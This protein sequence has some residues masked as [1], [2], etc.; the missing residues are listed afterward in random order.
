MRSNLKLIGIVVGGWTFLACLFTPQ[1]YLLNLRLPTPLTWWEALL[2]NLLIFYLWAILTPLIWRL[3]KSLPLEK[4]N[5]LLHFIA[6][7]IFGFP[8]AL[9][10]LI[11]LQQ[12]GYLLSNW[13]IIYESP[14]PLSSLL[15]GMGASNIMLYWV[16]IIISQANIHFRRYREREQSLIQ[17]QLQVLKN[18]LHPHFLFNT[19][20]AISQLVYE[21]EEEAEKTITKLSELLRLSLKSEQTQEVTLREELDF[22]R[23]YLEIQE[24]LM[25][26]R[27]KIVWRI[28]P[29]ALEAFV[30]NMILQPL[31]EN[32]I[33]HG[34][35]PRISGGVIKI[36]ATQE[37]R[38]LTLR[39]CDDGIGIKANNK[40]TKQF[41]IGVSNTRKRL[42][43]LYG[44]NHE[45]QLKP[46]TEGEGTMVFLR[47][48]FRIG[49]KAKLYE[50]P[51]FD[52]G[53]YV[54]GAEAHPA[55]SK[56]G[57]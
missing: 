53:R 27:L 36:I 52:S 39:I 32:S 54:V 44:K 41:G 9:F 28:T 5:K 49:E 4:P 8:C 31:V 25:Q 7:F 48:P 23:M 43:H 37:E 33:R 18:Q 57:L 16:I 46:A 40:K 30:P 45:F 14:V 38:W 56:Q 6:I 19:L 26:D 35:T 50:N 24:T 51:H 11:L 17:A 34:I 15:I 55:L 42:R 21:N 29:A 10:H 1:T 20:N 47:I 3:G 2:S 22:L 12:A 13:I